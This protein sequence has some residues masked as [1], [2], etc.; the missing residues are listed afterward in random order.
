[1]RGVR[2]HMRTAGELPQMSQRQANILLADAGLLG[3][4][5]TFGD[6]LLACGRWQAGWGGAGGMEG[7]GAG[8]MEAE[9]RWLFAVQQQHLSLAEMDTYE[10]HVAYA[11]LVDEDFNGNFS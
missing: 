1:M 5:Y 11:E 9:D 3:S 10:E 4:T 6:E 8:G 7:A 2:A